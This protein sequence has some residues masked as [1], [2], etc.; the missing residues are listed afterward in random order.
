MPSALHTFLA[1]LF[2][3]RT[4]SRR[5][6]GASTTTTRLVRSEDIALDAGE[7]LVV[8]IVGIGYAACRPLHFLKG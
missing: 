6:G 8:G 4:I 7:R 2:L 1:L 3:G 5:S